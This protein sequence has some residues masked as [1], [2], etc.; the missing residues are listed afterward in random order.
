[1]IDKLRR[2]GAGNIILSPIVIGELLAGFKIGK[3][4][5]KNKEELNQFIFLICKK[6][7]ISY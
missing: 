2:A 6:K 5:N 4:E 3:Q 1:L 7:I